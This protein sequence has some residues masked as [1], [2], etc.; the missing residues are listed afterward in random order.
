MGYF[1]DCG[2]L[3]LLSFLRLFYRLPDA[4]F[5]IAFLCTVIL[6][7]STYALGKKCIRIVLGAGMGLLALV[8]PEMFFF[9]PCLFYLFFCEKC[10][11][12]PWEPGRFWCAGLWEA[13]KTACFLRQQEVLAFC[14]PFLWKETQESAVP[15]KKS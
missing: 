9:Y 4:G 6:V 8:I 14:L 13:G 11:F 2:L 12:W 7:C 1:T 15:W 10:P 3:V 5:L